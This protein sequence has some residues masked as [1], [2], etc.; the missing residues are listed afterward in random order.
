MRHIRLRRDSSV[1]LD[2]AS[3]SHAER[4]GGLQP[5]WIGAGWARGAMD[6]RPSLSLQTEY[7]ILLFRTS[8]GALDAKSCGLWT[9]VERERRL[10]WIRNSRR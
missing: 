6:C 2:R 3:V 1:R 8:N 5:V 10:R 4:S 9:G 7:L